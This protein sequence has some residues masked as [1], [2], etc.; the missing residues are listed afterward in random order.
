M[1]VRAVDLLPIL[2]AL[3]GCAAGPYVVPPSAPT[4]RFETIF[5]GDKAFPNLNVGIFSFD[6]ASCGDPRWIAFM[7][8]FKPEGQGPFKRDIAADVPLFASARVNWGSYYCYV[9]FSLRPEVGQHYRILV[10]GGQ[11]QCSARVEQL[12]SDKSTWRPL[13]N[14][15]AGDHKCRH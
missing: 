14:M 7:N 1:N 6:S 3:T 11:W 13:P 2:L 15:S 5:V 8:N 4:A 12:M 10:F 9:P